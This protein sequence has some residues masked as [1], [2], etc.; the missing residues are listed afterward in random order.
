MQFFGLYGVIF[1]YSL[2]TRSGSKP[3]NLNSVACVGML[4]AHS[5]LCIGHLAAQGLK[6]GMP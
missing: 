6:L 4:W 1:Q 5:A 3:G 2:L